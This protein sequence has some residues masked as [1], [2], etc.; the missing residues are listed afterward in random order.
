MLAFRRLRGALERDAERSDHV[1]V[2]FVK[3]LV[4]VKYGAIFLVEALR[5]HTVRDRAILFAAFKERLNPL[6]VELRQRAEIIVHPALHQE[7]TTFLA[8]AAAAAS[9]RAAAARIALF[10]TATAF[11]IV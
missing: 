7:F 9:A 2:F 5:F 3:N 11:L 6:V 10:A 8:P 1:E 4:V